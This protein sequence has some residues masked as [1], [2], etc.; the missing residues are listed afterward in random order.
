MNEVGCAT[1]DEQFTC[2]SQ[3]ESGETKPCLA[4]DRAACYVI[5]YSNTVSCR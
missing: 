3:Q 1:S 5:V 4:P 2:H